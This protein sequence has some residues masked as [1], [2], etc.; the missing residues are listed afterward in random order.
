MWTG[1]H[2][3]I[4]AQLE[5]LTRK[6]GTRNIVIDYV[7][8]VDEALSFARYLRSLRG[9]CERVIVSGTIPLS[10]YQRLAELQDEY[11]YEV[12]YPVFK[13]VAEDID[14]H[15]AKKLVTA[16]PDK[17]VYQCYGRSIRRCKV[18]EFV[19]FKRLKRIVL[20]LEDIKQVHMREA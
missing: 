10:V 5:D 16:N 17:R 14:E 11:G 12:W 4:P 3:L 18:Y 19:E 7:P 20:E 6:L 2:T 9:R 8:F 1:R 15:E 13:T